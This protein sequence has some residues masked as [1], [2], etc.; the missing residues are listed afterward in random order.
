M[1]KSEQHYCICAL[2][3]CLTLIRQIS[4]MH[5]P[6]GVHGFLVAAVFITNMQNILGQ[7]REFLY[8]CI[9]IGNNFTA[10]SSKLL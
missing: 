8:L 10:L 4:S 9:I 1:H 7:C 2:L 3:M 5:Y 6:A